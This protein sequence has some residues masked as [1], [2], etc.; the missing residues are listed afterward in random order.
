[1]KNVHQDRGYL[2][3]MA[4]LLFPLGESDA[5]LFYFFLR[6]FDT[7]RTPGPVLIL[8]PAQNGSN[9]ATELAIKIH[10]WSEGVAARSGNHL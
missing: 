5:I 1:M 9:E 4:D 10:W 7:I 2:A 6:L 8:V 3:H